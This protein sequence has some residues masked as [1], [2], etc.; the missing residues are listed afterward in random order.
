KSNFK[1]PE[2]AQARFEKQKK[3]MYDSFKFLDNKSP[4][5]HAE[6]KVLY[7]KSKHAAIEILAS[8]SHNS[9]INFEQIND[10]LLLAS[11]GYP[12]QTILE[13]LTGKYSDSL[14][15]K[16]ET[17]KQ[18]KNILKSKF[19]NE[20]VFGQVHFNRDMRIEPMLGTKPFFWEP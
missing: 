18:I 7:S 14:I 19:K 9:T 16:D 8:L 20:L 6:N 4:N 12:G 2:R 13:R 1:L 11:F 15:N 17:S 5:N 10:S 3:E